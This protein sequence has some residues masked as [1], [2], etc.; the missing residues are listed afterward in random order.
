[1]FIFANN[2]ERNII[3]LIPE[4]GETNIVLG[5]VLE[6]PMSQNQNLSF[7]KITGEQDGGI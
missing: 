2:A 5:N 7:T 3:K 4:A 1:L 6:R